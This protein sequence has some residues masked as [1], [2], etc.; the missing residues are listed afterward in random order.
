MLSLSCLQDIQVPCAAVLSLA[1][2][3]VAVPP[4]SALITVTWPSPTVSGRPLCFLVSAFPSKAP[5]A[6]GL[7]FLEHNL[8]HIPCCPGCTLHNTR[9]YYT[10]SHYVL[11]HNHV[12]CSTHHHCPIT[13]H[14][15]PCVTR[16]TL[17]IVTS[18]TLVTYYVPESIPPYPALSYITLFAIH[19]CMVTLHASLHHTI[20]QNIHCHIILSSMNTVRPQQP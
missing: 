1:S 10:W 12:S 6:A 2:T 18:S 13:G 8:S 11:Q 4:A 7:I 17:H 5:C 3:P 19:Y 14:L 15:R 20:F 16:D 9:Y